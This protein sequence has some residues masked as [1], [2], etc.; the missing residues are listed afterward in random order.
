VQGIAGQWREAGDDLEL[1]RPPE[2]L[3]VYRW[4]AILLLFHDHEWEHALLQWALDSPAFLIGA[5]G[6]APAREERVARLLEAGRSA[7]DVA[8]IHSP[9]GLIPRARDPQVLALSV[10]AEVVGAYENLHPQR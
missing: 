3:A 9:V 8:R 2:G 7:T 6:G 5:Q 1:G 4:T 10:L